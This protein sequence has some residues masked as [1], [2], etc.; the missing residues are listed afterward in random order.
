MSQ[1]LDSEA[2]YC[3][4]CEMW[5][6]GPLQWEDHRIGKKHKKNILRKENG[7]PVNS[8][9]GSKKKTSTS[10]GVEIPK[11]TAFLIEQNAIYD[12]AVAVNTYILSLYNRGLLRA[13]L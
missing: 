10:K 11:G 2:V 13:R 6:N 4:V 7:L 8:K 3:E 12:D 5:L 9:C 1:L